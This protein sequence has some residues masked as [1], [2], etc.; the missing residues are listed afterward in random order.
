MEARFHKF[1]LA[2]N[3]EEKRMRKERERE[4]IKEKERGRKGGSERREGGR[5]EGTHLR[6]FFLVLVKYR[7][8]S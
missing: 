3:F 1:R 8:L 5:K 7:I 6:L 4:R 2:V